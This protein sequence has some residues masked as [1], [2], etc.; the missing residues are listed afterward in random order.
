MSILDWVIFTGSSCWNWRVTENR[1][2][3][4]DEWSKYSWARVSNEHVWIDIVAC[5]KNAQST[6]LVFGLRKDSRVLS[7]DIQPKNISMW[8]LEKS[9]CRSTT[10]V[11]RVHLTVKYWINF[12]FFSEIEIGRT[13]GTTFVGQNV[14]TSTVRW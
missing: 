11:K 4:K 1:S 12:V 13:V 5:A 2:F 3:E 10:K 6:L 7:I 8:K 14:C 9:L